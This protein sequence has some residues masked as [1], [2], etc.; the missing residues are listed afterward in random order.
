MNLEVSRTR[1]KEREKREREGLINNLY[2]TESVSNGKVDIVFQ[3]IAKQ[4][5]SNVP[6]YV[7]VCKRINVQHNNNSN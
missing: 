7:E 2:A 5:A 6:D 3:N 1:K 4:R